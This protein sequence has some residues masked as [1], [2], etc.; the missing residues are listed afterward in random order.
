MSWSSEDWSFRG[1]SR[2]QRSW[3]STWVPPSTSCYRQSTRT[4]VAVGAKSIPIAQ[5]SKVGDICI[6]SNRKLNE[7]CVSQIL[8]FGN[9][10]STSQFQ[11][12]NEY[13]INERYRPCR[14]EEASIR[15][16]YYLEIPTLG[17]HLQAQQLVSDRKNALVS[18]CNLENVSRCCIKTARNYRKSFLQS[19]GVPRSA[20][21]LSSVQ[22]WLDHRTL[23]LPAVAFGKF[24]LEWH[25]V[26]SVSPLQLYRDETWIS[27][28]LYLHLVL[29]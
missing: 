25:N 4:L 20:F 21:T 8:N 14:S 3:K 23:E 2:S 28:R 5:L 26:L 19:L 12:R 24:H 9:Q 18:Y 16:S 1:F 17:F 15:S 22:I 11:R 6:T 29:Y 13:T 7:F 27:W 10:T